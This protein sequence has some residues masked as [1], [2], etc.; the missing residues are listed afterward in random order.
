MVTMERLRRPLSERTT[1]TEPAGGLTAAMLDLHLAAA[2]HLDMRTADLGDGLLELT[3][4][5]PTISVDRG[6]RRVYAG[7]GRS[8]LSAPHPPDV[9]VTLN[10]RVEWSLDVRATGMSGWLDLHRVRLGALQ[11]RAAGARVR[12]ELPAPAG[13]VHV[14]LSGRGVHATLAVPE[15]AVVRFWSEDGWEVDGRQGDGRLPH[16]R[17]DVWL[18]GRGRCQVESR[19]AGRRP[20]LRVV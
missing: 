9:D 19:A 3:G 12:V 16:D 17:Y 11:L 10:D 2:A 14:R 6:A 5:R 13:P 8:W 20:L 18:D 7:Q 15:G 1:L 4:H